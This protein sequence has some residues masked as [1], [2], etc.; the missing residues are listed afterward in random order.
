MLESNILGSIEDKQGCAEIIL[1]GLLD[2]Y[3]RD[4]WIQALSTRVINNFTEYFKENKEILTAELKILSEFLGGKQDKKGL[5]IKISMATVADLLLALCAKKV[6]KNLETKCKVI[7][8]QQD[9]VAEAKVFFKALNFQ[10]AENVPFALEEYIK[11]LVNSKKFTTKIAWLW[12]KVIGTE[13]DNTLIQKISFFALSKLTQV[14]PILDLQYISQ[15]L[16]NEY[17]KMWASQIHSTTKSATQTLANSAEKNFCDYLEQE[18]DV[19]SKAQLALQLLKHNFGP[20]PLKNFTPTRHV[21]LHKIL[22]NSMKASH[23]EEYSTHLCQLIQSK[24]KANKKEE[25]QLY[26]LTQLTNMLTFSSVTIR[27]IILGN[28]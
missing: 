17:V 10:S 9:Q 15:L 7:L 21:R 28:A 3:K 16:T 11:W 26:A 23:L 13:L 27:L 2:Y 14:K 18:L 19:E 22:M 25:M 5:K 6:A 24:Q 8:F 1:K 20:D 12:E 4:E